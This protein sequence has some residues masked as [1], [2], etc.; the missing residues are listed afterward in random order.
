[1]ARILIIDD[2]EL[3]RLTLRQMLERAGHDV[4]EARNGREGLDVY[5]QKPAELVITDIIMPEKEGI[6]TI[7]ELRRD[8]PEV[9]IVAISGGGRM[10]DMDYLRLAREFGAHCVLA[11]PFQI[12][13]VLDAIRDAMAAAA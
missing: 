6:E 4:E 1:M 10:K 5:R 9:R 8:Y 3:V 12:A 11:K 13:D 2:E 7:I